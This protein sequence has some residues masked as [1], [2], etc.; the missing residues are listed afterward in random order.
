[1]VAEK[2]NIFRVS[3]PVTSL[4]CHPSS[5]KAAWVMTVFSHFKEVSASCVCAV[6]TITDWDFFP[7]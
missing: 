2:R 1:M 7:L 6:A 5:Q 4:P 3:S